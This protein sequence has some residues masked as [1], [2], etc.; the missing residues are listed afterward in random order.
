MRTL[1][2]LVIT[3]CGCTSIANAADIPVND[4]GKNQLVIVGQPGDIPAKWFN[5]VPELIQTREAVAFTLLLQR[6]HYSKYGISQRLVRIFRSLPI[7]GRMVAWFILQT[8]IP[9]RQA[10]KGCFRK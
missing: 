4:A 9:F 10:V 7:S 1:L 2:L 5:E 3:F 8:V 6:R